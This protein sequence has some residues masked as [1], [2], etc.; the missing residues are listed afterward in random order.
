MGYWPNIHITN[1]NIYDIRHKNHHRIPATSRRIKDTNDHANA[2]DVL[3]SKCH[4]KV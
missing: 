2:K 3:G 1:P 4:A